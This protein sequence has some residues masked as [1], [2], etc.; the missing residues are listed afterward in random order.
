MIGLMFVGVCYFEGKAIHWQVL[1]SIV[2]VVGA[3]LTGEGCSRYERAY[4]EKNQ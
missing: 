4:Y 3:C 2:G 1:S